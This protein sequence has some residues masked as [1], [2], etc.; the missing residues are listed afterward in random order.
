MA[1]GDAR[2]GKWRGKRRVEWVASSLSLHLRN[3]VYPALL[4]LM[5]TTRLPVVDWTDA[6][7]DLNGLVRFPERPNLVSA[8]VPSRFKRAIL[9]FVWR[10]YP[11]FTLVRYIYGNFPLYQPWFLSLNFMWYRNNIL[12]RSISRTY[13]IAC[14]FLKKEPTVTNKHTHIVNNTQSELLQVPWDACREDRDAHSL[15]RIHHTILQ[16]FRLVRCILWVWF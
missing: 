12:L 13:N 8:R 14:T 5:R 15:L 4:P 16:S 11:L 10:H 2:E 9:K 3:M 7:A 6:P 1:H